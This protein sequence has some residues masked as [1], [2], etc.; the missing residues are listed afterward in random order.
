MDGGKLFLKT[1]LM[2]EDGQFC[3]ESDCVFAFT[4]QF[5]ET[6]GADLPPM[7]ARVALNQLVYLKYKGSFT[8]KESHKALI[9]DK[10][11]ARVHPECILDLIKAFDLK[12][13]DQFHF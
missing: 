12:L 10:T 9:R 7:I 4:R 3:D 13:D 6:A 2:Q 1:A 8:L 11:L 5:V